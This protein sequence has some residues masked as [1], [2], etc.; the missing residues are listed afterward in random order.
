MWNLK[1]PASTA[2][3]IRLFD[4]DFKDHDAAK[5]PAFGCF[6]IRSGDAADRE[7]D[8]EIGRVQSQTR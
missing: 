2:W 3:F 6:G 1:L 4:G 5:D 7:S 8:P